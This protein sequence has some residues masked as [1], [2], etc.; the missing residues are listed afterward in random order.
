MTNG[1]PAFWV[2][3]EYPFMLNVLGG[4]EKPDLGAPLTGVLLLC[5]LLV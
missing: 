3:S 5:S 2:R 4:S 1:A